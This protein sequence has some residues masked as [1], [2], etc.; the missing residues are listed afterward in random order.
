MCIKFD[1]HLVWQNRREYL[2]MRV[3]LGRANNAEARELAQLRE[4]EQKASAAGLTP[5]GQGRIRE[6]EIPNGFGR[7]PDH[8]FIEGQP[9]LQE[10]GSVSY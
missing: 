8:P 5:I 1:D 7:M 2:E 9:Q 3:G 6:S 10:D 4:N